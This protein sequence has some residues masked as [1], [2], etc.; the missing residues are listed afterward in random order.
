[1]AMRMFAEAVREWA[2][3]PVGTH[4]AR[5]CVMLALRL[6]VNATLAMEVSGCAHSAMTWALKDLE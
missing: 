3:E 1:M 5:Y 2:C 6:W 4:S